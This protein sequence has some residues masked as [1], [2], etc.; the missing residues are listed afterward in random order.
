METTGALPK[1]YIYPRPGSLTSID[2]YS[3][4]IEL[5]SWKAASAAP[6]GFRNRGGW[7]GEKDSVATTRTCTFST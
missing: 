5:K 4:T 1:G 7:E 3:L 6:D 2:R